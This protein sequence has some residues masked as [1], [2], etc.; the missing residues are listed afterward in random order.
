M[1]D[2]ALEDRKDEVVEIKEETTLIEHEP[3]Y[4]K[5]ELCKVMGFA[6]GTLII[7]SLIGFCI[8]LFVCPPHHGDIN[9]ITNYTTNLCM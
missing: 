8:W 4:D 6:I 5:H 2:I 7:I 1:E 9:N 3:D